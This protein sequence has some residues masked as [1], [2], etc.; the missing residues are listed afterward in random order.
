MISKIKEFLH[1]LSAKLMALSVKNQ[2]LL[3]RLTAILLVPLAIWLGV[4]F[5]YSLAASFQEARVWLMRPLNLGCLF[6]FLGIV[7]VHSHLGLKV[8]IEDYIADQQL[9]EKLIFASLWG[10]GLL[11]VSV[12]GAVIILFFRV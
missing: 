3:Q 8:I 4:F 7:V 2:W 5:H 6:V 12:V 10:F 9:Q 1:Q 11:G